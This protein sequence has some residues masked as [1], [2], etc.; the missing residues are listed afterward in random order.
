MAYEGVTGVKVQNFQ[1]T[2]QDIPAQ[3]SFFLPSVQVGGRSLWKESEESSWYTSFLFDAGYGSQSVGLTSRVKTLLTDMGFGIEYNHLVSS[4]GVHG[5]AGLGLVQYEWVDKY[6]G[7]GAFR[8]TNIGVH[9]NTR[10][11]WQIVLSY[12]NRNP[13]NSDQGASV[14]TDSIEFGTRKVW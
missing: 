2:A 3:R 10:N 11:Q 7:Q 6:S 14:P 4:W 1:P 9:F 12:A 8:F 13:L 5:V